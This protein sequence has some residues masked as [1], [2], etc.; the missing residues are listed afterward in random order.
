MVRTS[1]WAASQVG[2][3]PAGTSVGKDSDAIMNNSGNHL[4]TASGLQRRSWVRA[5]SMRDRLLVLTP[6]CLFALLGLMSSSCLDS[7]DPASPGKARPRILWT[8]LLPDDVVGQPTVDPA[9]NVL[10]QTAARRIVS[11]SSTGSVRWSVRTG[12]PSA[13]FLASD[14]AGNT[15]LAILSHG[16]SHLLALDHAGRH[17]WTFRAECPIDSSPVVGE[18]TVYVTDDQ[19]RL[20]ALASNGQLRWAFQPQGDVETGAI[21]V[22]VGRDG[23]VYL[24]TSCLDSAEMAEKGGHARI[25]AL[26]SGGR[27]RW[28]LALP[29]ARAAPP[30]VAPDGTL[31]VGNDEYVDGEVRGRSTILALDPAG[32]T[33]WR[34]GGMYIDPGAVSSDGVVF[35]VAGPSGTSSNPDPSLHRLVAFGRDGRRLFELVL[36]RSSSRSGE[37]GLSTPALGPRGSVLVGARPDDSTDGQGLLHSIDSAGRQRWV[38]PTRD[39]PTP[40]GVAGDSA[41]VLDGPRRVVALRD[42]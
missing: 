4:K 35:A 5:R 30:V 26:T 13:P 36:R 22:S 28:Q 8:R 2:V 21:P 6:L 14:S 24:V 31:Y 33:V 7:T 42:P 39:L 41:Y 40:L 27:L 32:S 37:A 16:K 20:Y 11:L 10:L 23:S 1:R 12:G 19:S 9:G 3:M 15:Y 17:R 18:G 38:L 29:H 34:Q 25:Y